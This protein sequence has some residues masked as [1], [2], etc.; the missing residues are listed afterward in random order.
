MTPNVA[1]LRFADTTPAGRPLLSISV[2]RHLDQIQKFTGTRPTISL[3]VMSCRM[4]PE[5]VVIDASPSARLDGA[6]VI[7]G[8]IISQFF[9]NGV[10][11]ADYIVTYLVTFSDGSKEPFD[12]VI[13]VRT[14]MGI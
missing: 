6:H 11:D 14:F 4:H 1:I 10:A 7:T 13:G 3:V 5:S 12:A 9:L 8:E 2:T